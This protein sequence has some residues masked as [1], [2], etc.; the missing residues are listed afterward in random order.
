MEDNNEAQQQRWDAT[1]ETFGR[2]RHDTHTEHLISAMEGR[3]ERFI[4]STVGQATA[5]ILAAIAAIQPPRPGQAMGLRL[6][7]GDSPMADVT[8]D[9]DV[10]GETVKT[11]YVD[12]RGDVTTKVPANIAAVTY[13]SSDPAVVT[14]DGSG[15]L[16]FL[17]AGTATL[18][19]DAV[20][21]T[22]A[23]V[24][25]FEASANLTLTPGT[26]TALQ[27]AVEGA[28]P[29]PAPTPPPA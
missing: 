26:A 24:T 4:T 21:A 9:V 16:S 17:K 22:G 13:T 19:A 5:D 1:S 14:V 6:R 15:A 11:Q 12:D 7:I 25:G 10:T 3:L 23:K 2:I 28:A 8:L 29:V 20:D 18:T 27:V